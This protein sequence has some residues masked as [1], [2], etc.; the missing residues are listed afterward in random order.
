MLGRGTRC[1][2]LSLL[3]EDRVLLSVRPVKMLSW[4]HPEVVELGESVMGQ[5][6]KYTDMR[7]AM[8]ISSSVIVA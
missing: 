5:K 4:E 3:G 8:A 2:L 6:A 1:E 7:A